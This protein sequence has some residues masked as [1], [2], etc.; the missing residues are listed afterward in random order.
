MLGARLRSCT[1]RKLPRHPQVH[2]QRSRLRISIPRTPG[3]PSRRQPQQ[4]ELAIPLHS[5]NL[6]TRKLLLQYRWIIDEIRLPQPHRHN[7]PPNDRLLQPPRHRLHFRKFRHNFVPKGRGAAP[8]RPMS[9]SSKNSTRVSSTFAKQLCQ[10]P[11]S[12]MCLYFLATSPEAKTPARQ[13]L[14]RSASPHT[15]PPRQAPKPS[16]SAR[17]PNSPKESAFES[18]PLR[19]PASPH[20]HAPPA[21]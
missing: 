15:S 20:P 13:S 18:L 21:G 1:R 2:Q 8:L 5:F 16:Q 3:I 11:V 12:Q 9:T 19:S 4:H 17:T 7:A 10:F 14:S 6:S